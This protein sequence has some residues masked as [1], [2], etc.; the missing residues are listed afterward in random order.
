MIQAVFLDMDGTLLNHN[1]KI[2]FKNISIIKFI[3]NKFNI[4]VFIA[5][6]RPPQDMKKYY[7]KLNLNTPAIC[8]NGSYIIDLY[9]KK[10]IKET[11]ISKKIEVFFKNECKKYP[12]GSIIF[13]NGCKCYFEKNLENK[14][15]YSDSYDSY[16]FKL[17]SPHKIGLIFNNEN[18][19]I[20]TY[21]NLKRKFKNILNIHRSQSNFIEVVS[22]KSCKAQAISF[23]LKNYYSNLKYKNIM[24]IG[25]SD[26]DISMIKIAGLG[27]AMGNAKNHIKK[28]ANVITLSNLEDGVAYAIEKYII[29]NN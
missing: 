19:L 29:K 26:N 13:Y 15:I 7:S 27:I 11:T 5:T 21:K 9:N 10:V 25:D 17:K 4:P 2:S 23:I 16:D 3:K 1:G 8:M 18:Y 12:I 28:Q 6:G 24:T 22:I 20:R 14:E